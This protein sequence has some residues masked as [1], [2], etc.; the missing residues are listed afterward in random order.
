MI[1]NLELADKA[2]ITTNEKTECLSIVESFKYFSE[3]ARRSGLLSLE[4]D[5]K[6][7]S[8]SD[9]V[10]KQGIQL[11]VDGTDPEIIEKIL[12]THIFYGGYSG[13]RLLELIMILEGIL[14]LQSGVAPSLITAHLLSFLGKTDFTMEENKTDINSFNKYMAELPG[15]FNSTGILEDLI[16]NLNNNAIQKVLVEINVEDLSIAMLKTSGDVQ[17][18]IFTNISSN[19]GIKVKTEMDIYQKT[20]KEKRIIKSQNIIKD[21]IAKLK[22]Y[23]E[24]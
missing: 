22:D 13:K 20:L 6:F 14:E 12:S 15:D 18:K 4:Y 21:I 3:K 1:Y 2:R 16:N 7:L 11:V 24:I 5:E 10:F 8:M 19:A 17:N 23:G 9:P